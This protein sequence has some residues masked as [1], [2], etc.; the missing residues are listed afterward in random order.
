MVT[1]SDQEKFAYVLHKL[2]MYNKILRYSLPEESFSIP[3]IEAG[4]IS[5]FNSEQEIKA[6]KMLIAASTEAIMT[7]S[8]IPKSRREIQARKNKEEICLAFDAIKSDIVPMSVPEREEI[9]KR[10]KI[11]RRAEYLRRAGR[12]LK[13]KGTK[14]AV[15]AA[16]TA[17]A[18][19][20]AGAPVSVPVGIIYGII[21]LIPDSWKKTVEKKVVDWVEKTATT[22]ENTV[23]KFVEAPFGKRLTKAVED[24]KE[25]KV[26][27]TIRK[28]T[29]PAGRTIDNVEKY[30]NKGA[31]MVLDFV[32][33][34]S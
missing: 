9:I 34:F 10:N 18:S 1:I 29:E 24:I 28:I 23:G 17:I 5:L 27:T 16:S 11:V 14:L 4:F 25:S 3:E 31:R 7:N 19:A 13:R 8:A 26:I 2:R 20:I 32:K 33:S 6:K 22:I 12:M 21:A 30:V 15:G